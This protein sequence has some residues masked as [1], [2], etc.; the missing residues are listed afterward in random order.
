MPSS[1]LLPANTPP[2]LVDNGANGPSRETSPGSAAI[3]AARKEAI[4]GTARLA[5]PRRFL[6]PPAQREDLLQPSRNDTRNRVSGA[7][8]AV[9]GDT[10]FHHSVLGYSVLST[11]YSVLL[12]IYQLMDR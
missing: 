12:T 8:C 11:G 1:R 10:V 3:S 4:S 5:A 9:R 7:W 2:L 6:A